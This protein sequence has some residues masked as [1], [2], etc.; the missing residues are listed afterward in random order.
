MKR[1]L[2]QLV[3][4]PKFAQI[5]G[6]IVTSIVVFGTDTDVLLAVPLGIL[7]GGLATF[8]VALSDGR[9]ASR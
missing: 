8:F 5:T 2:A 6:M 9:E 1:M 3:Q 4:V 7:A